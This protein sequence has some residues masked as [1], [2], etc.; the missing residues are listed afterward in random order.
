MPIKFFNIRSKEVLTAETEPQIAALWASSD[1][2][3]NITQGQDF[4]WRLAPAVV[5]EMKKIKQD[6]DLLT[7]IAHRYNMA[8]EDVN[9]TTILQYISDHTTMQNAAVAGDGDFTDEYEMEIRRLER[10]D[11]EVNEPTQVTV[12]TVTTTTEVPK[13][14]TTTTTKAKSV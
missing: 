6:Y 5:V 3:P 13:T 9:E 2:S 7:S 12:E 10:Q 4:G 8:T 11:R 14:T 1:H